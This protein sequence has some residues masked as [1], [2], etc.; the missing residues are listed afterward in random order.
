MVL[1][2]MDVSSYSHKLISHD[3]LKALKHEVKMIMGNILMFC[4]G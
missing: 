4:V 2:E 3:L 1:P